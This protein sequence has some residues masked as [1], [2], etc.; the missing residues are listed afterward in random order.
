MRA[1]R[2]AV[3][4]DTVGWLHPGEGEALSR[5]ATLGPFVELGSFAGKSTVWL[6]D[7]AEREG[8]TLFA[9]DWHRGSPEIDEGRECH[10]PEAI[11]PRTGRHDTLGL[12]RHTLDCA[13]LEDVVV[14]VVGTTELVG[15]WWSTPIGFLFIDA[16]HDEQVVRDAATW[17]PLVVPGGVLCFH[18]SPIPHIERAIYNCQQDGFELVEVVESLTVL[19]RPP[20]EAAS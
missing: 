15:R 16:C 18:D 11:D 17:A 6:G 9:V 5:H 20:D 10:K 13:G 7:A 8:T 3:A 19:R 2:V 4:D 12:L 1:D 14:P